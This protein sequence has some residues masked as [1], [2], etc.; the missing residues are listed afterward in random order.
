MV[1]LSC[2]ADILAI[3]FRSIGFKDGNLSGSRQP[4][5]N[6]KKNRQAE[7]K[8]GKI[9]DSK[10]CVSAAWQEY[11][12]STKHIPRPKDRIFVSHQKVAK[13]IGVETIAKDTLKM[14]DMAGIDTTTFKSHSTRMSSASKAL[15]KGA[16]VD[17]VM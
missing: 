11:I 4:T 5:K 13:E 8:Y 1:D 16:S 15:E 3:L 12:N 9:Q 7:F 17:E 14:M 2:S 6:Y 10:L